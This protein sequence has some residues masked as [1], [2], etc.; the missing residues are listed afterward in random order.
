MEKQAN[1]L[2]KSINLKALKKFY[3]LA[4]LITIG[5]PLNSFAQSGDKYIINDIIVTGNTSF[6]ASTIITYSRLKKDQEVTVGGDKIGEAVKKLWT[7][8]MIM[9]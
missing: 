5:F 3:A 6:N 8:Y 2:F 7:S 4:L 9:L 1:S